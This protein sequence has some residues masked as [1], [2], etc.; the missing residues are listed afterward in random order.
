MN[1]CL[2]ARDAMPEGG[3]LILETANVLLDEDAAPA[4]VEAGPASSCVCA[5]ATPATAFR[6]RFAARIFEPFFTTKEP[7]KGTGLGL[8]M[9]F[10]IVKQHAG[11]DRVPKQ[12]RPRHH[13]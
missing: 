7:G 10:G 2:N 12:G 5:S 9:V 11:L 1:L 13:V 8:A 3:Q 4:S 6:R